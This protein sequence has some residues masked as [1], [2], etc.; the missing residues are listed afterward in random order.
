ML[1]G[2]ARRYYDPATKPSWTSEMISSTPFVWYYFP[3]VTPTPTPTDYAT[4]QLDLGSMG[5]G[6][7]YVNGRNIGRYWNITAEGSCQPEC[8]YRGNYNEGKCHVGCGEPTQRYYNVP[9]DWLLP[10]PSNN[11]IVL[12]EEIGGDPN[13]V[14]LQQRN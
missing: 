11:Y 7:A 12:F 3:I 13:R 5:K 2:E 8:D 1:S 10:P 14:V 4:W 6:M 9:A